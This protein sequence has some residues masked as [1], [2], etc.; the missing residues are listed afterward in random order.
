MFGTI[1]R[2]TKYL[3]IAD[4]VCVEEHMHPIRKM[5]EWVAKAPRQRET[6][7]MIDEDAK[8]RAGFELLLMEKEKI[9]EISYIT[10]SGSSRTDPSMSASTHVVSHQEKTTA[11]PFPC[12]LD[13]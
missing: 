13:S 10:R 7:E 8:T 12:I 1:G 6:L 4:C 2:I 3:E 5:R 11:A 9:S